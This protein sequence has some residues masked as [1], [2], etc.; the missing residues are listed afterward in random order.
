M[1]PP[2]ARPPGRRAG[3]LH[4]RA[5]AAAAAGQADDRG[6]GEPTEKK[7]RWAGGGGGGYL[8]FLSPICFFGGEYLWVWVFGEFLGCLSVSMFFFLGGGKGGG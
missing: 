3:T 6:A 5:A 8:F 4:G 1:D 2:G 7:G